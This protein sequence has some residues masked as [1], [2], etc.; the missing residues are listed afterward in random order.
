[1]IHPPATLDIAREHGLS[2]AEW[3]RIV[4]LLGRAPNLTELGVFSAMWNEHCSYKSSRIHLKKFPTKGPRVLQGPGEN[5]GVVDLGGGLAV[6]FKME[7][8]NHPSFIEPYQGAAT[9]VGGIL[10]DVF[11]M[12]ARPIA[13]LDSLRFGAVNHDRTAYLADGVVS[14]I[15]GYGNCIGVPTVGG[16]TCFHP[17]YNGNI[18]VNVMCVGTLRADAIFRGTASGLGNPVIYVGAATGRDGIHGA[19]MAS[20]GFDEKALEKRPTVQVGDPFREKLLLEACLE[21]M[22][23]GSVVGI[24]DMGAAGLT[25]SSAEMAGRAGTGLI[26]R[27]DAVPRR[28]EGMTPYELMLSESQERMLLVARRGREGEVRKIFERWDLPIAVVGEVTGDG[29][30][31]VEAEGELVADLPVNALTQ[32]APAYERPLRPERGLPSAD[33]IE[34]LPEEKDLG[35]AL[36]ALLA[37]PN[38]GLKKPIWRQYDHMVRTNTLAPPGGDAALLRLK[39]T[40][41]ALALTTDGNSRYCMLDPYLGGMLAVAEAA[42]NLSCTGALPLAMT[43]CLNFGNPERPAV[44]AQF[45]AAIEGMAEACRALGVPVVSGNVSFYNETQGMDIYPTPIVGMVGLLEEAGRRAGHGLS[46]EGDRLFLLHPGKAA[47]LPPGGAHEYVWVRCGREG[48]QPPAISLAA[49]AAVQA[50]C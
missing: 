22:K 26:L 17:C 47:P 3:E 46:R 32:E 6:A 39:G 21:L 2:E 13:L 29:R 28:E 35:P 31:R 15:A 9:G 40:S 50:L 42:R 34:T 5:A 11:T 20:A 25:S 12:G 24:Q 30:L 45:S 4:N 27:L 49:E 33:P 36:L 14:G 23:R 41:K 43:N 8:H 10:R 37:H 44:M 48:G 1:M 19:S 18:L 38:Q 16:E 7:S